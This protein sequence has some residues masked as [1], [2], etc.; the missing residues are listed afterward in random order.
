[1]QY[2]GGSDTL[3][4]F[5][6]PAAGALHACVADHI[7]VGRCLF[8]A[9]ASV[10]MARAASDHVNA[11]HHGALLESISFERPLAVVEAAWVECALLLDQSYKICSGAMAPDSAF[12]CSRGR[13]SP[14]EAATKPYGL[15]E[16]RAAAQAAHTGALYGFLR[17][18]GQE[19]GPGYQRLSSVWTAATHLQH[20]VARL[21]R[22]RVRSGEPRLQLHPADLDSALQL[23]VAT[24]TTND[25]RLPF[26]MRAAI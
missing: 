11:S 15:H 1:M 5:R 4:V 25:K 22:R 7:V 19:Y 10:E 3:A 24:A 9:A 14:A 23:S 16:S 20:A 13:Q 2:Y 18:A 26:A 6:S 21:R 8:P 12:V 17:S